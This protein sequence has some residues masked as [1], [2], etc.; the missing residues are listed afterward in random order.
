[1]IGGPE[2][3]LQEKAGKIIINLARYFLVY[4]LGRE[5]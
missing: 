4:L 1:M 5:S 2:K 3:K